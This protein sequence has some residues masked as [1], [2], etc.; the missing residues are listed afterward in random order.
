[1]WQSVLKCFIRMAFSLFLVSF[2]SSVAFISCVSVIWV[3]L[4]LL[5]R[6]D[7]HSVFSL[8]CSSRA[9]IASIIFLNSC[10]KFK[11]YFPLFGTKTFVIICFLP[12]WRHFTPPFL[13]LPN[14]VLHKHDDF[15]NL[16]RGILE[17]IGNSCTKSEK[18]TARRHRGIR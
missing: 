2:L 17:Q 3:P 7:H 18:D 8:R 9:A 13:F 12:L 1:M 10:L 4:H 6:T 5:W 16:E 11:W 14:G 15:Y